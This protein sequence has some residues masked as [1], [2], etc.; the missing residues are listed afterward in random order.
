MV[1]VSALLF[2][3]SIGIGCISRFY[4]AE[5][6]PKS[7]L[8]GTVTILSILE[9]MLKIALDFGFYPLAN[10]VGAWS[11]TVFLLPSIILLVLIFQTCPETKGRSVNSVLNEIAIRLNRKVSF[12]V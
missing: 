6:V 8:L 1:S 12:K 10:A 4:S 7:L 11:F 5:L 9:S 3:T 2:S